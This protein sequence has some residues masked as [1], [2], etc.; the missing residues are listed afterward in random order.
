MK[1]LKNNPSNLAK[2]FLTMLVWVKRAVYQSNRKMLLLR[3]TKYEHNYL[4][5]IDI[6]PASFNAHIYALLFTLLGSYPI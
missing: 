1:M 3:A 6:Q 2:S 5:F 4:Q